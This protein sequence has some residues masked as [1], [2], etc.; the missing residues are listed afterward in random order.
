MRGRNRDVRHQPVH[1]PLFARSYARLAPL[2]DERAGLGALRDELLTGLTGRVIE[3]G[4]GSGLNFARYPRQVAEVVAIEPESH[5]RRLAVTAALRAHVPVD[6]VPA[7]AEALPVKSEAFDA[8][9]TALVLCSVQDLRRSLRELR[10]VLRPGGELRF[11]EHGRARGRA[12]AL[13]QRA[14]D[15]TVWPALCGGCHTSRDIV[16]E[17]RRAGFE[18]DTHRRLRVPERG[19]PLP[20]SSCVLGVARRLT[21]PVDGERPGATDDDGGPPPAQDQ[22]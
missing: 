15:R 2:A 16:A 11:L 22:D 6:V 17:V 13:T 5:L 20:T 3:I 12:M 7:R 19:L 10:R 21:L 4:A 14:L 9:V 8:V 18:I 1:H